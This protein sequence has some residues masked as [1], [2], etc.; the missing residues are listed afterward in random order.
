TRYVQ[1]VAELGYQAG[2]GPGV[3]RV[4]R[5]GV[6]P[7]HHE[8]GPQADRSMV[9]RVWGL[10]ADP[11]GRH[12]RRP[13][14][15]ARAASERYVGAVVRKADDVCR[16]LRAE[17]RPRERGVSDLADPQSDAKRAPRSGAP[18][19]LFAVARHAAGND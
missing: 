4:Y 14:H 2:P 15:D 11:D 19:H 9:R 13:G 17:D 5:A 16:W 7:R 18:F 10:P 12:H 3:F 6:C 8:A 1:I